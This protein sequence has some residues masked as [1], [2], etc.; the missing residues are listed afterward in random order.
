MNPF[1]PTTSLIMASCKLCGGLT[2]SEL[3]SLISLVLAPG[4]M[5]QPSQ[6]CKPSRASWECLPF[7][8]HR[9]SAL[10]CSRQN[11]PPF[12][13][14]GQIFVT[15]A[16]RQH[17][18]GSQVTQSPLRKE[19]LQK[20]EVGCWETTFPKRK[21]KPWFVVFADF[22]GVNIPRAAGFKPPV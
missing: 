17:C 11:A 5:A 8:S 9:A 15:R 21:P 10:L 3:P 14:Q 2:G 7:R 6:S 18:L 20:L 4:A 16:Q 13:A 19:L 1:S 22:C 12:L